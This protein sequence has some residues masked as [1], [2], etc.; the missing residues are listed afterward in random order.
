MKKNFLHCINS[1]LLQYKEYVCTIK[2]D[3]IKF[4]SPNRFMTQ[5]EIIT[6]LKSN[7]KVLFEWF[8]NFRMI[9]V[10]HESPDI[11]SFIYGDENS[12]ME[13]EYHRSNKPVEEIFGN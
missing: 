10:T 1:V 7:A 6:I 2:V 4:E 8:D 9:Y 13:M 5:G 3:V 11:I 12:A